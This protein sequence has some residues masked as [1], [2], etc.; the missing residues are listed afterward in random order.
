MC[1]MRYVWWIYR[2][3][4]DHRFKLGWSGDGWGGPK[5][6]YFLTRTAAEHART[7]F[8]ADAY[9]TGG[10]RRY[11]E[12]KVPVWYLLACDPDGLVAVYHET[13]LWYNTG[14]KDWYDRAVRFTTKENAAARANRERQRGSKFSGRVFRVVDQAG[15]DVL[16][17]GM[18]LSR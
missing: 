16:R 5:A 18:E 13:F 6:K 1:A 4:D 2:Y 14:G 3:D 7:V 10:R 9:V 15:I 12:T 17:I 8:G 11:D